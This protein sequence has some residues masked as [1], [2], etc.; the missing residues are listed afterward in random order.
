[1][2]GAKS[3]NVY[4]L[5]NHNPTTWQGGINFTAFFGGN[6]LSQPY[7]DRNFVGLFATRNF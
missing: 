2:Q 4:V 7:A 1:M 3:V 5:F 6:W